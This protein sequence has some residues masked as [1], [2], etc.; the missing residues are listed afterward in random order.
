MFAI[1]KA[2]FTLM[3]ETTLDLYRAHFSTKKYYYTRT[4]Y[5]YIEN[6]PSFFLLQ[7]L[8]FNLVRMTNL[9]I[10]PYVESFA[11]L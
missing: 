10:K 1:I 2:Y 7:S 9:F 11:I 4:V 3:H 8:I 5:L 6:R